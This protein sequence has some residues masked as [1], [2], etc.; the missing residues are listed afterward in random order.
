M[1]EWSFL[2]S[3]RWAGYLALVIVFAIACCAL[4]P[5]QL[6]RRAEALAEV[7]RIDA[8]YDAEA[9][10]VAEALPDPDGFDADQRWQV[11]ALSGE[12]LA[13]EAGALRAS[14]CDGRATEGCSTF[15]VSQVQQI[16]NA[17][18]EVRVP[19]L[20]LLT[21][22]RTAGPLPLEAFGFA[23]NV[24]LWR[25]RVGDRST[26]PWWLS[27]VG[28]GLRVNARGFVFEVAGTRPLTRLDGGWRT[29]F[30]VGPAF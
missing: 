12:Y 2:R 6:N 27:S 16:V 17:N 21:S 15:R 22:R 7:A 28:G 24:G 25:G 11:V 26:S 13:D 4:G 30:N 18:V 3:R 1:K 10:P 23:D 19:L 20:E 14:D 8:N 5:W 29:A 9:I